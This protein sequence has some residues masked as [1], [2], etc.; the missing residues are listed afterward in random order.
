MSTELLDSI[1]EAGVV[2][3]GGAGFP[4]HV[5]LAAQ[6]ETLIVNAS[7]CEPLIRV[8][9]QLLVKRSQDFLKGLDVAMRLTGA[10]KA[11]IAIKAKHGEVIDQLRQDITGFAGVEVFEMGDYYP[12]GDEQVMVY[13]VLGKVV[14]CGAIPLT[15]GCVV[16]N[17]E[18]LINVASATSGTPVTTTFVTVTGDVPRPATYE[19][20]IG[21]SYREA[22]ALSGV[23][24]VSGQAAID[25]G[26][27][28]G[29][30]VADLDA[31][32]TKTTKAIILL[33]QDMRLV[34][35]KS[36]SDGLVLKQSRTACEQCQKCTDL[37]P[38]DLLGHDVK[39]HLVMRVANYGL[40][41]FQGL[42]RA[43]GCSECGACELYACPVGL[44]PRRIN[45]MIKQQL[46]AAGVKNDSGGTAF[47]AS[48]LF[49]FRKIPVKR[50]IMRLGL[51]AYDCPAPLTTTAFVPERVEILLKQHIGVPAQATVVIG[52]KVQCGDVVGCV[53]EG[54][55]GANV[56][57]SIDG[58]VSAVSDNAVVIERN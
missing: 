46:A 7:E 18:T 54:Q 11:Y 44:S 42:K 10:K 27:M 41:D 49:D 22:L 25:G 39:P 19:L 5:K 14:P 56:H 53:T 3:A 24:D 45:V 8:D 57:A 35:E 26:A 34:V 4:T 58:T 20:P 23:S 2:G 28:M 48:R 6:A 15:V 13:D 9:Q 31:P 38:R 55:L 52:D 47:T 32:I 12:A 43:L 30:L 17:V 16:S 36:M 51:A 50:L 29:K 1:R 37:C 40:S 21:I 33:A